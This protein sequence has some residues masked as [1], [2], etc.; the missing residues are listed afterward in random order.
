MAGIKSFKSVGVVV[1]VHYKKDKAK[2]PKAALTL[3]RSPEAGRTI[4]KLFITSADA[5]LPLKVIP[6]KDLKSDAR[7][8][9]R[10]FRKEL[11][12]SN[13]MGDSKSNSS[14]NSDSKDKPAKSN[15]LLAQKQSWTNSAGKQITAAIRIATDQ[16]VVF[17][18]R[19]NKSVTYPM[20][21]LS[22]KSQQKIKAL[23]EESKASADSE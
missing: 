1:F 11:E 22:E 6:Y 12:T 3:N 17:I 20:N 8:S 9:A 15:G 16:S 2:L 7:K 23:I 14:S 10:E 5:T 13:V 4:P 18:M 21:K 19:N